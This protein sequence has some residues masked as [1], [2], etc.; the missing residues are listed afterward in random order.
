MC[1]FLEEFDLGG[2]SEWTPILE[3]IAKFLNRA[4]EVEL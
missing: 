1:Y 2:A 4:M 3:P